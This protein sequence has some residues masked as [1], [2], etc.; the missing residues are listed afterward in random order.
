MEAPLAPTPVPATAHAPGPAP[1]L[2]RIEETPAERAIDRGPSLDP[3]WIAGEMGT[4]AVAITLLSATDQILARALITPGEQS[5][6]LGRARLPPQALTR[7]LFVS[8]VA[9]HPSAPSDARAALLYFCARRARILDR[10]TLATGVSMEGVRG[11][12]SGVPF[13]RWPQVTQAQQLGRSFEIRA[14]R[15]DL[16]VHH[17]QAALSPRG[18]AF[19][20]ERFVEEAVE[21]LDRWLPRFFGN[22]WFRAIRSGSLAKPQYVATLSN[23]HQFVRWT[24]RLIGR[25]VGASSDAR[26]RAKWLQHLQG[27]VDHEVILERD[28]AALG[29]DV[30][31]VKGA[32]EPSVATQSFMVA[33]ESMIAFHQDPVLFMAAPFVAEGF[34]ARLDREFVE[35]LRACVASWGVDNPKQATAFF[36]SHI[37]YDGGSD[38]HW[39]ST[40]SVLREHLVTERHLQRFLNAARLCME[41]FDRAYAGYVEDL[42]IFGAEGA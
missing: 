26:V 24:T 42:A 13:E 17:A 35:A 40:R 34:A 36:A 5:T 38:G 6:L 14:E 23:L 27:E 11:A 30:D 37:E 33:Q 4:G 8:D 2:T 7:T 20:R 19:V 28:L 9:V 32:M 31:F 41:A 25:A 10:A 1:S 22:A 39:E 29:A 16:T 15:V 21:T 12:S 3:G 18:H